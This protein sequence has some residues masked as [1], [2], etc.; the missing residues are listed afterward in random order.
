MSE[1]KLIQLRKQLKFLDLEIQKIIREEKYNSRHSDRHRY[2]DHDYHLHRCKNKSRKRC[3]SSTTGRLLKGN[4]YGTR[5]PDKSRK[6]CYEYKPQ[7]G[8]DSAGD[9]CVKPSRKEIERSAEV[10]NYLLDNSTFE[11]IGGA[12]LDYSQYSIK[13]RAIANVFGLAAGLMAVGIA[14]ATIV[15]ILYKMGYTD[16][17]VII[18]KYLKSGFN[19][20]NMGCEVGSWGRTI[21]SVVKIGTTLPSC[22]DMEATL[23]TAL[24][25]TGIIAA[26]AA[27]GSWYTGY[28]NKTAKR[29]YSTVYDLTLRNFFGCKELELS[30]AEVSLAREEEEYEREEEEAE[31]RREVRKDALRKLRSN[32]YNYK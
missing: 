16:Y 29:A 9:D 27:T 17:L 10:I 12:D 26:T 25:N 8:G 11:Q 2:R 28:W 23:E 22:A 20:G 18:Y 4:Y 32:R 6:T 1:A 13:E 30:E 15:S 31:F 14:P 5:C 3:R 21:R 24:R 19:L 7:Q